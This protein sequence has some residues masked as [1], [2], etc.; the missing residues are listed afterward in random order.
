MPGR[1]HDPR[2]AL[3]TQ[4]GECEEKVPPAHPDQ[5]VD[6]GDPWGAGGG[7]DVCEES[8]GEP[9]RV[10]DLN[11]RRSGGKAGGEHPGQG[12]PGGQR[13]VGNGGYS[14][15]TSRSHLKRRFGLPR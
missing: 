14:Q 9:G 11:E 4:C 6:A 2:A 12:D 3:C 7:E 10:F 1:D 15:T 13:E 8:L 5:R